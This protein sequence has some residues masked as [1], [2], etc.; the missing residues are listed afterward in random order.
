[1]GAR[2]WVEIL[3]IPMITANPRSDE[4]SLRRNKPPQ[5]GEINPYP[6]VLDIHNSEDTD[7]TMDSSKPRV[8]GIN[9]AA[10]GVQ[11]AVTK[12]TPFL[13]IRPIGI[14]AKVIRT[15]HPT[16]EILWELLATNRNHNCGK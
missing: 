1:M 16:A 5:G 10:V 9:S 14:G 15:F 11:T 4:L 13:P 6:H 3:C 7:L 2:P 12:L 8:I